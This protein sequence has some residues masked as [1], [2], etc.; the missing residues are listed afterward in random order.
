MGKHSMARS[1]ESLAWTQEPWVCPSCNR[2]M[3]RAGSGTHLKWCGGARVEQFWA[4]VD[5][6][7]SCWLYTGCRDK[8]GY[9]DMTYMGKHMQ[10]HRLAWKL[11]RGDPGELDVLHTCDNAPCCNPDHLYLGTDADNARDRLERDRNPRCLKI[12]QVRA[13]RSLLGTM[14]Q[15]D[16]ATKLN[17]SRGV[18]NKINVGRTYRGVT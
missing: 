7:G 12:E 18:V 15:K 10:A 3:V 17:V 8:W 1:A 9:G 4:N 16:I 6:T 13:I 11:L 2:Q 14:P 5:K